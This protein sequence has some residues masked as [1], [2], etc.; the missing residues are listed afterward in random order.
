MARQYR[1]PSKTPQQQEKP[2]RT[3][4]AILGVSLIGIGFLTV[5]ILL[6]SRTQRVISIEASDVSESA[7]KFPFLQQQHCEALAHQLKSGD[8]IVEIQ[9]AD[10]PEVI[11]DITINNTLFLLGQC[12]QTNPDS[13][14]PKSNI[15]EQRGTSVILLLERIITVIEEKRTK[16]LKNPVVVTMTLQAAEP[17]PGQPKLDYQRIKTLVEKITSNRGIV[18]IMGTTGKLQSELTNH[19]KDNSHA[20]VCT[21]KDIKDCVG[22]SFQRGREIRIN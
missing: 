18:A 12:K 20:N 11:R 7:K 9:F 16:G 13:K 2:W 3:Y 1:T 5:P 10:N 6:D 8:T 15:G 22:S 4:P 14:Q 17:G 19:L 21:F